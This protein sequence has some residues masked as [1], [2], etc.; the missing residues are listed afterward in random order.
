M[1]PL[2][3]GNA[4]YHQTTC[5]VKSV[6][7]TYFKFDT[8]DIYIYISHSPC[9]ASLF[10]TLYCLCVCMVTQLHALSAQQNKH[11]LSIEFS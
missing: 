3:C 8:A 11:L 4:Q 9:N 5:A 6:S 10:G 1:L 7:R 2:R